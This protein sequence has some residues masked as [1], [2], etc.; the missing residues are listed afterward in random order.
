MCI[1]DRYVGK[2]GQILLNVNDDL[3]AADGTVTRDI[4]SL[5]ETALQDLSLIH[6]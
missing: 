1:R 4:D 3:V 5:R 2:G 6:I